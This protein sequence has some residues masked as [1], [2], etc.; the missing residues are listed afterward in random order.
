ML[1]MIILLAFSDISFRATQAMYINCDNSLMT[2]SF[3]KQ[4]EKIMQLFD[5]RFKQ[6]IKLN[7]IPAIVCGL[8]A[9]LLLFYTGGQDYPF[10]YLVNI[11]ICILISVVNSITWLSLYYLFQPFTTSVNV[12]SGAYIAA[13]TVISLISLH[14]CWIPCKSG[15]LLG[16]MLVFTAAYVIILRKLVRKHSPKTWKVKS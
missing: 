5:I 3:F 9:N 15:L 2:F 13:R 11:L 4:R 14:I 6:L 7:I 10:Q 16:I 8:C 12:K 1:G